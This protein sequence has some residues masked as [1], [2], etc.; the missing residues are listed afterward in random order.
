MCVLVNQSDRHCHFWEK[1][2]AHQFF[3]ADLKS[4]ESKG[5][6]KKGKYLKKNPDLVLV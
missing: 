6:N 5:S 3:K 4:L 2:V 1:K